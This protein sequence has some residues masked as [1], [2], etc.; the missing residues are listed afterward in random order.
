MA[1]RKPPRRNGTPRTN[2][3]RLKNHFGS[4]WKKHKAS[5]L[6]RRGSGRGRKA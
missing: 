6:P 3:E 2:T 5:E 4:D 1:K